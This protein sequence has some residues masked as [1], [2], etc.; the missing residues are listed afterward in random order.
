MG[1]TELT[2]HPRLPLRHHRKAESRYKDAF[3]QQHVTHLYGGSCF[4]HDD[5]HN[6][7]FTGQRL[8]SQFDD[9]LT[10]IAHVFTQLRDSF[11]V[12][13][14]E[15]NC[16]ER[17]PRNRRRKCIGEELRPRSLSERVTQCCRSGNKSAGCTAKSFTEC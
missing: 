4:P 3:L 8:E 10:E 9:L 2:T 1:R 11:G 17:T 16:C 12:C 13:L 15:T 7:G 6:G 14:N 5:G